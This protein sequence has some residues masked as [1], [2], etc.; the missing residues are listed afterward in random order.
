MLIATIP[1]LILVGHSVLF[2]LGK[3][4]SSGELRYMLIVAPFWGLLSAYGWEWI[5]EKLNW[6]AVHRAAGVAVLLPIIANICYP[7]VPLKLSDDDLA[8]KRAAEWYQH[9]GLSK[10]FPRIS[11]G[12]QM[13]YYF[14]GT[15]GTDKD[16]AVDWRRDTLAPAPPGTIAV[17]DPIYAIYNSDANRSISVEELARSG[18]IDIT[19][20]V[21]PIA[22]KWRI[23]LSPKTASGVDADVPAL[24][25]SPSSP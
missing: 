5:F 7:C 10:D 25:H 9:S 4:A 23:F 22:P 12:H 8:A 14:L 15:I 3:M 1:L 2:A 17:W 21:P 13:L 16:H 11:S 18:W 20:R 19:D 24:P 6:T